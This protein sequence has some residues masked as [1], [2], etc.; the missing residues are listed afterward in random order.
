MAW[1]DAMRGF[2]ALC[3]VFEH[4]SYLV[5][6]PVRNFLYH[7]LDLGQYGVFVFFLVSG[8][9]IPASLERKGSIR[10]FWI[11][12]GFR[13]YPPYLLAL[14][15]SVIG[16]EA[17]VT[18]LGG[19]QHHPFITASSWL[20]MIPNLLSGAN[21]P[22][23]TWTL[24]YEMVFYLLVAALFSVRAHRP[25]GSY[26]L[27]CAV[28][29]LAVGGLLPMGALVHGAGDAR[30]TGIVADVLLV[31]GVAL[32]VRYRRGPLAIGGGW[33]AAI[34]ALTLLTVNQHYP[35]PWEGFTI[36]AFMFTGTLIYRAERGDVSRVKAAVIAVAV[37]GLTLAAGLW[38][39]SRPHAGS[40]AT[41]TDQWRYQWVTS[42]GLAALTFGLGLLMRKR[43]VPRFL[44]WLGVVSYSVYLLHPLVLDAFSATG[45]LRGEPLGVQFVLFAAIVAAV[46]GASA[47]SYYLLEKPMQRLGHRVAKRWEDRVPGSPAPVTA[48]AAELPGVAGVTAEF[49]PGLSAPG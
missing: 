28:V 12:R 27:A 25:S 32:A 46:L 18:D 38:N 40:W 6:A 44:A 42:L 43:R 29:A 36:L 22:N 41:N 16:F 34:V 39:G 19:A 10:G 11:G 45:I 1:L 13:L 14:L 7:W 4:A 23:V 9:I 26:A 49:P 15:L 3:V 37:L 35:Y 5:L 33:L 30:L 2:A 20:L 47:A 21:V 31:A 8:Y 17:G 48:P 24:S